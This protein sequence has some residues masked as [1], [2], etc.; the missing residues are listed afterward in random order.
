MEFQKLFQSLELNRKENYYVIA[1]DFIAKHTNSH[2]D[3]NNQRG[4]FLNKWLLDNFAE[5]R[6]KLFISK[7]PSFPR[8]ESFLD[9]GLIDCRLEVGRVENDGIPVVP[10]DSDHNAIKIIISRAGNEGQLET[11]E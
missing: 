6:T 11:Q 2:N 8:A 3:S 7:T 4:I 1:G 9:V 10:Y 5:Y